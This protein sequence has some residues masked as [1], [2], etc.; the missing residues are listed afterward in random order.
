MTYDFLAFHHIL[1]VLAIDPVTNT[2][3]IEIWV[4]IRIWL[5][6]NALI[7]ILIF[8]LQGLGSSFS[9]AP[10]KSQDQPWKDSPLLFQSQV[11]EFGLLGV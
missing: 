11:I 8:I 1:C 2:D 9:T 3:S 6:R 7:I 5:I 10:P 4:L